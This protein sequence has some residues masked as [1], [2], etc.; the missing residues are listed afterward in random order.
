MLCTHAQHTHTR[1]DVVYTIPAERVRAKSWQWRTYITDI[2][3]VMGSIKKLYVSKYLFSFT[4]FP[5]SISL[6]EKHQ[7]V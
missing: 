3:N 2:F 6:V 5:T 4:D 7:G 1:Y